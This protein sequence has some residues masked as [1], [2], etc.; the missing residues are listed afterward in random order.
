MSIVRLPSDYPSDDPSD[1]LLLKGGLV[2]VEWTTS[3]PAS[4]ADG[5]VTAFC[6]VRRM[7]DWRVGRGVGHSMAWLLVSRWGLI[8]QG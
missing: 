4:L 7:H 2:G 1:Y 5:N 6:T 8:R 3:I